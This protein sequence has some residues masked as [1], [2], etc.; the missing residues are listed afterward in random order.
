MVYAPSAL[1]TNYQKFNKTAEELYLSNFEQTFRSATQVEF[2][3]LSDT[4][5]H[6]INLFNYYDPILF[7]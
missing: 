2:R 5:K 4:L 6:D 7:D 3:I 1:F